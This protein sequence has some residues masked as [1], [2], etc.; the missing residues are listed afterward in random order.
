MSNSPP[1]EPEEHVATTLAM[2]KQWT[3]SVQCSHVNHRLSASSI[4][5]LKTTALYDLRRNPREFD[6][7]DAFAILVQLQWIGSVLAF[8]H[9]NGLPTLEKDYFVQLRPTAPDGLLHFMDFT[10]MHA[11]ERG[12]GVALRMAMR[13]RWCVQ[14]W[15]AKKEDNDARPSPERVWRKYTLSTAFAEEEAAIIKAEQDASGQ[16]QQFWQDA[17]QQLSVHYGHAALWTDVMKEEPV[18][19][20]ERGGVYDWMKAVSAIDDYA[21]SHPLVGVLSVHLELGIP[22][23]ELAKIEA[24]GN[25]TPFLTYDYRDSCNMSKPALATSRPFERAAPFQPSISSLIN[26]ILDKTD[27]TLTVPSQPSKKRA[28]E[29][30]VVISD[31]DD[32]PLPPKPPQN[33]RVCVAKKMF[34]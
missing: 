10:L 29:E 33:K 9:R 6:Y 32:L 31:E 7:A 11:Y 5:T 24:Q 17:V 26:N 19:R 18:L 4:K 2:V 3:P 25:H 34:I 27:E 23:Q 22:P 13:C 8:Y 12:G 14:F 28:H 16:L 1:T 15:C 20:A 21:D 30:V